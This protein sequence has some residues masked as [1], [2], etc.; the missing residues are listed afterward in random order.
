MSEP[1]QPT[2]PVFELTLSGDPRGRV[3]TIALRGELGAVK[4]TST[5]PDG[6]ALP[7]SLNRR[8]RRAFH[9]QGLVDLDRLLDWAKQAQ[10]GVAAHAYVSSGSVQI[11]LAYGVTVLVRPGDFQLF[12]PTPPQGWR[13]V[14]E[15][16]FRHD[17]TH[18]RTAITGRG[19]DSKD[20]GR[21]G[22]SGVRPR[23]CAMRS[24]EVS[25][26]VWDGT[27]GQA[28]EIVAWVA[29]DGSEPAQ[30][31]LTHSLIEQRPA[32]RAWLKPGM[33]LVRFASAGWTSYSPQRFTAEFQPLPCK[34]LSAG[35]EGI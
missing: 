19:R 23:R 30:H 31:G 14:N 28:Q 25:A 20:V 26:M 21:G 11:K 33:V 27:D 22:G 13:A 2:P 15:M 18:C 6:I 8:R 17:R 29:G 1:L 10:H 7:T 9:Y 16:E 3:P 24:V 5:V 34:S 32:R 4:Q 35:V 12:D